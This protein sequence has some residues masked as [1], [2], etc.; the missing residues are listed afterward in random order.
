MEP[1]ELPVY[2]FSR[3]GERVR[4][5]PLSMRALPPRATATTA[6]SASRAT[7]RSTR[8]TCANT[9]AS[10]AQP[11]ANAIRCRRA[12]GRPT[13]IMRL[14]IRSRGVSRFCC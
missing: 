9:S 2:V 4:E 1:A 8:P 10:T 13:W 3:H 14:W 12:H 6:V 11:G 5:L 7:P